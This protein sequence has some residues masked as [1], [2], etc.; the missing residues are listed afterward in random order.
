MHALVASYFNCFLL[1]QERNAHLQGQLAENHRVEE[2]NRNELEAARLQRFAADA[3]KKRAEEEKKQT[4]EK[5]LEAY[6]QLD[7][8]KVVGETVVT[9]FVC[10]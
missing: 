7:S 2:A 3:K 9:H 5:C 8:L 10:P 6:R 1:V 4:E